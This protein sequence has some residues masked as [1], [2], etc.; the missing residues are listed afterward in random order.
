MESP[1]NN[2]II[3]DVSKELYNN[4]NKLS[5]S[6]HLIVDDNELNK[7]IFS[8]LLKKNGYT[9]SKCSDGLQVI[10]LIKKN[11]K[12]SIIWMDVEMP[13]L[14]GIDATSYLRTKLNYTGKIIGLT[15]HADNLTK[16]KCF[17]AGMND[18]IVKPIIEKTL[19]QLLNKI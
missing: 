2:I 14:N 8:I 7:M 10:D 9:S 5:S 13:N 11:N 4:I 12:Y 3:D 18:I 19:I 15:G 1:Y 16:Q 17:E 6:N